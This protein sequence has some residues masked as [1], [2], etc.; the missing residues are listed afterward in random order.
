MG[1]SSDGILFYGWILDEESADAEKI[2][3]AWDEAN[4][5][6]GEGNLSPLARLFWDYPT[7]GNIEV[8][9]H[10]SYDYPMYG[11]AAKGSVNT[12]SRGYPERISTLE[13]PDEWTM[14]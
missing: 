7:K 9:N 4:E 14:G 2:A 3:A 10:C 8:V 13:V 1:I 11:I 12:N 6:D 5:Y